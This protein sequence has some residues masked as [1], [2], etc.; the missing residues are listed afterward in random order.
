MINVKSHTDIEAS[1][2]FY[3]KGEEYYE[4]FSFKRAANSF[5][6]SISHNNLN[7]KAYD[8]LSQVLFHL[9]DFAGA[10]NVL[11]QATTIE[12]DDAWRYY[13][14]GYA[15]YYCNRLD[16][17]REAFDCAVS[18]APNDASLFVE[19]SLMYFENDDFECAFEAMNQAV[20]ISPYNESYHSFLAKKYYEKGE[21]REAVYSYGI[22]I[23]LKPEI[24]QNHIALAETLHKIGEKT[25]AIAAY[26]RAIDCAGKNSVDDEYRIIGLSCVANGYLVQAVAIYE[27]LICRSPCD[28]NFDALLDARRALALKSKI[29]NNSAAYYPLRNSLNINI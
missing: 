11:R 12:P 13:Y 9:A 8:K 14:L 5:R 28:R 16:E 10:A 19:I 25:A 21:Y 1:E 6:R 26:K 7:V 4:K 20:N 23:D 15:Y 18:L 22:A 27:C 2:K 17:C 29:G 24:I 3:K